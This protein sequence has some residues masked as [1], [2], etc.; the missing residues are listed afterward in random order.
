MAR[1]DG[2]WDLHTVVAPSGFVPS[3]TALVGVWAFFWVKSLVIVEC[4]CMC[5][6]RA[7][8]ESKDKCDDDS[9]SY[10]GMTTAANLAFWV[11]IGESTVVLLVVLLIQAHL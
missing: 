8:R 10:P 7:W 3:A 6:A 1:I 9:V 5:R 2:S 4:L 11:V